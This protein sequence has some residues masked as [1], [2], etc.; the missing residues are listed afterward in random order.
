MLGDHMAV[1]IITMALMDVFAEAERRMPDTRFRMSATLV[2]IYNEKL[3]DLFAAAQGAPPPVRGI[4]IVVR[5]HALPLSMC[6]K[7]RD[8]IASIARVVRP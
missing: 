8:M 6:F 5:V 7:R 3:V 2:E 4:A 1:G